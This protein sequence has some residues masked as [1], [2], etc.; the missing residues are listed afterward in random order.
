MEADEELAK[1]IEER[2]AL[3]ED[4]EAGYVSYNMYI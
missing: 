3:R 2:D 4:V 1:T